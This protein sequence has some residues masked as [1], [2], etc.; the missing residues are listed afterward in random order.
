MAGTGK[1]TAYPAKGIAGTKAKVIDK[2]Q[3]RYNKILKC[4]IFTSF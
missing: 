4:L 3:V 2:T 1:G